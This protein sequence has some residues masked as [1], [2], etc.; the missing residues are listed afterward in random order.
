MLVY[1]KKEESN[2]QFGT[3]ALPVLKFIVGNINSLLERI[4]ERFNFGN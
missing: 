2:L 3:V 4:K 1:I